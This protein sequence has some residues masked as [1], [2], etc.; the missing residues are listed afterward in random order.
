[1]QG[2]LQQLDQAANDARTAVRAGNLEAA[3]AALE[4][5]LA[6]D[7]QHPVAAE[8]SKQLDSRFRTQADVARAAM[9]RSLDAAD[10]ARAST[11]K[12]FGDAL[13]AAGE[14]ESLFGKGEFTLAAQK[15]FDAR[16]NFERARRL[17]LEKQAPPPSTA[18]GP[19][20]TQRPGPQPTP[21]AG[22][23][24]PAPTAVAVAPSAA[25]NL[26]TDDRSAVLRLIAD[27][28]RAIESKDLGLYRRLWPTLSGAQEKSLKNAFDAT[29][30]QDVRIT[31]GAVDVKGTQATV[32]LT[33]NDVINGKPVAPIKQTVSLVK[34]GEVWTIRSIGQ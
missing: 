17:A 3:S 24:S 33:R 9:K 18:A 23:P 27:Y 12:S 5:V 30:Q 29:Q 11:Q 21:R 28:E 2:T 32:R 14:A 20:P 26:P 25:P 4:R 7:P 13:T 22:Q 16:D 34:Q 10:Q 19:L 8:L 6:I 15:F 1:V 31:L